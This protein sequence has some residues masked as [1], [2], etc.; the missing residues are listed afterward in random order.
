M[1]S[2]TRSRNVWVELSEID[3]IIK[4][5]LLIYLLVIAL[6]TILSYIWILALIFK[7]EWATKKALLMKFQ[8]D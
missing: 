7:P 3:I 1:L 2:F 4:L 5:F 8:D 6:L